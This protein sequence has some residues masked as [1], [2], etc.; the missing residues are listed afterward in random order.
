MRR[1]VDLSSNYTTYYV[2]STYLA[3][4]HADNFTDFELLM[5]FSLEIVDERNPIR[6]S[7]KAYYEILSVIP[8]V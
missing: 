1:A 4:I 6:N 7:P 3:L 5:E 8:Y 2:T